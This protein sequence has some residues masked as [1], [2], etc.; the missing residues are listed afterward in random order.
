[1]EWGVK[2][3]GNWVSEGALGAKGLEETECQR[4]GGLGV[5]GEVGGQQKGELGVRGEIGVKEMENR[6]L[7]GNCGLGGVEGVWNGG[8]Q[9]SGEW[10]GEGKPRVEEGGNRGS[11]GEKRGG[12]RDPQTLGGVLKPRSPTTPTVMAVFTSCERL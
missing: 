11:E 1:M 3:R 4:G 2:G 5:R 7:V 9:K 12:Q 8:G 10:G 6:G